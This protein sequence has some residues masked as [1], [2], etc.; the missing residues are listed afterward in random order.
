MSRVYVELVAI[1]DVRLGA[2][3]QL[4]ALTPELLTAYHTR[5]SDDW[6]ALS[7]PVSNTTM[8]KTLSA[9]D[10][11]VLKASI[12]TPLFKYISDLSKSV[13]VT[14]GSQTDTTLTITLNTYPYIL[15]SEE[16]DALSSLFRTYILLDSPI[17]IICDS[18]LSLIPDFISNT[19]DVLFMYTFGQWVETHAANLVE[20]SPLTDIALVAPAI[21][22]NRHPLEQLE[23]RQHAASTER[24]LTPFVSLHL[25]DINM[26]NATIT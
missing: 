3:S 25:Q 5:T 20:R 7:F 24:L 16:K 26:F 23:L 21:S 15:T 1:M 6:E 13:S 18:V 11:S 10:M 14:P 9:N 17:K 2:L 12:V 8:D 19:Y 22:H 4:C